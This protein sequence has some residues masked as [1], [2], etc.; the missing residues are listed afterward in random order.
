MMNKLGWRLVAVS[1]H[2][3]VEPEP[4]LPLREMG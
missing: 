4:P 2:S 1:T 3:L